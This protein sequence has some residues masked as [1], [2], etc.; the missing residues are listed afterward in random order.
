LPKVEERK[1]TNI[2]K[3]FQGVW[4]TYRIFLVHSKLLDSERTDAICSCNLLYQYR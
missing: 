3:E 2:E 4:N 1:N